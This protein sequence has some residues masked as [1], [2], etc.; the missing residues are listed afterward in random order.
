MQTTA[1]KLVSPRGGS[2]RDD[3]P[4][5]LAEFFFRLSDPKLRKELE[6]FRAEY[7]AE[8]GEAEL[9]TRYT[10]Q[11]PK[12]TQEWLLT[13]FPERY[14]KGLPPFAKAYLKGKM[15][16]AAADGKLDDMPNR[17]LRLFVQG[18]MQLDDEPREL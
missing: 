9:A 12:H 10:S 11:L 4:E 18:Q 13:H 14:F 15:E 8:W 6:S 16:L 7:E 2:R 5:T 1:R 3:Q 17:M